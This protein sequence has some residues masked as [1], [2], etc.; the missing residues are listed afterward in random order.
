MGVI[1][2]VLDV[3]FPRWC[4]GCGAWDEHLC[5]LCAE[6]IGTQFQRADS[7][8]PYLREVDSAGGEDLSPFPVY[9]LGAYS[10]ST[11]RAIVRWK[12]NVDAGL[13]RAMLNLWGDA[14]SQIDVRQAFPACREPVFVVP[15]PSAGRRKHE[16]RFIAGA[17]A[18]EV[19]ARAGGPRV[20]FSDM[21]KVRRTRQIP[22]S[23]RG[24]PRNLRRRAQK[25]RAAYATRDCSGLDV[26]LVDDVLTSGA[27]LSGA[28]RA[29][30]ESGGRVVGGLVIAHT[31]NPR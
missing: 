4:A 1:Q 24:A 14:V 30:T 25:A 8:A 29:V 11:S 26:I 12:N 18:A 13:N 16:G 15:V 31:E 27:T 3:V 5:A 6:V 23:R 21:L 28:S 2:Q 22:L 17:L 20:R 9:A 7:G 10:G 19:V